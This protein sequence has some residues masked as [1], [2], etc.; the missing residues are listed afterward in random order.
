MEPR[1]QGDALEAS[2]FSHPHPLRTLIREQPALS[3][4]FAYILVSVI[5][6]LFSFAYYRRFGLNFF[7]FS[8]LGDIAMAVL[9]EPVTL[10]LAFGAYLVVAAMYGAQYLEWRW[11]RDH[12]PRSW[13]M[14]RYHGFARTFWGNPWVEVATLVCYM[15]LF[16]TLYSDWKAT[17]VRSGAVETVMLEVAGAQRQVVLLGAT[18]TFVFTYDRTASTVDV[19]PHENVGRIRFDTE[20][21]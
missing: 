2:P 8:A 6:L 12:P 21:Q 19:I 10:V 15:W 11:F 1:A 3:V 13:L 20:P 5:G 14:R 7:N 18:T 17:Q 9:R 4:T 16:I